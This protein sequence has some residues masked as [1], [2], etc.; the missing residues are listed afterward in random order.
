MDL[1]DIVL[2]MASERKLGGDPLWMFL[3]GPPGLL[4][5][6]LCRSVSDVPAVYSLDMLTPKTLISG[7]TKRDD[8]GNPIPVAG[9]LQHLDG[10]V[11]VIKDFTAILSMRDD[12]RQDVLGQLRNSYDG[13]LEAG[14]GSLAEPIRV[15]AS[16]GLLAA[17]TPV[18][19]KHTKTLTVMGPRC[20]MTRVRGKNFRETTEKAMSNTGHEY[21]MRWEVKIAVANFLKTV[22]FRDYPIHENYVK[23]LVSLATYVAF[24]RSHAFAKYYR[25]QLTEVNA[26]SIEAPTRIVKQL[27]KLIRGL[28]SIRGH[29]QITGEDYRTAVRVAED[30]AIPEY[31]KIMN[32]FIENGLDEV[33]TSYII[34]R[35]TG[36]HN[37]TTENKCQIMKV[38]GILKT[39][40][41]ERSGEGGRE[42]HDKAW[43]LTDF[44]KTLIRDAE[45]MTMRESS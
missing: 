36:M 8:E 23:R 40:L 41:L 18:L 27:T 7:L 2:V 10:R 30:S 22:T 19:D 16:Y 25:G 17:V 11:L 4:K 44:F 24:M 26:P 1:I 3:V 13:Y 12:A 21:Q 9:L 6:E 35:D 43:A 33:A 14:F 28:A 34:S 15:R 29:D 38:I 20:L 32:W 39:D 5:T 37:Q 31:Q 42:F 45:I